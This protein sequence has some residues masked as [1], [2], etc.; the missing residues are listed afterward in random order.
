LCKEG[1]DS[2][3]RKFGFYESFCTSTEGIVENIP[4]V[5]GNQITIKKFIEKFEST[6]TPC[7]ISNLLHT[8]PANEK[9]TLKVIIGNL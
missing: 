4:R 7:V 9:W 1:I 3:W 2:G 6:Y 8:W 5:D